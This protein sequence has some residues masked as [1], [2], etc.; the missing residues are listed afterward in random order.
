MASQ[1]NSSNL[2]DILVKHFYTENQLAYLTQAIE[3]TFQK[4]NQFLV[5]FWD[6]S[7][8]FDTVERE[9]DGKDLANR[10]HQ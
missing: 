7:H 1:T 10:I 4:K 3:N 5:V 6:L 8:A 9:P 2:L